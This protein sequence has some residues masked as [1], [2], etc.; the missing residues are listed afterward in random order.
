MYFPPQATACV[1]VL[2]VLCTTAAPVRAGDWPHWRGPNRNGIS[3]EQLPP[4]ASKNIGGK[5]AWTAE[6]GTGFSSIAVA[7]DHLFTSG[8]QKG[9][10]T[11]Y[12]LKAGDGSVVWKHSFEA[13]LGDKFYEGGPGATPTIADG[14]VYHASKWGELFCLDASTGKVVWKKQ[15]RDETDARVPTW[16][17]NGSP[18]VVDDTIYLNVGSAGM[19]LQKDDGAILWQSDRGNPGYSTPLLRDING[20]P[21]LLLASG[22]YYLAV[23]PGTGKRLWSHRWVTRYGVNA[24]DPIVVGNRV[25]ISSGYNKGCALLE[26]TGPEVKTVWKSKALRNQ[27]SG[28]V[29]LDGYLYG[30][31]GDS[32]GQASLKCLE[33]STGEE[34]WNYPENGFGS[35]L[36]TRSHLLV[37]DH[38]GTLRVAPASPRGFSP[39]SSARILDGRCWTA[40]VLAN[41]RLYARN[42]SGTLVCVT[43]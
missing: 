12:C 4:Q 9:Q 8:H 30:I 42:A 16:G 21:T 18:T 11:L 25:F 41:Q 7:G 3:E 32:S 19:A 15:L 14:R 20:A 38:E 26:I 40:P 33:W 10:D 34:R 27:F 37:L 5:R 28:S 17:F 1:V 23:D 6:V 24:A 43:W 31:D 2:A 36:A 13:D 29:V 35:L 22:N 39:T